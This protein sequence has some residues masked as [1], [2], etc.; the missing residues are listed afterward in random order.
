MV[1]LNLRLS[2]ILASAAQTWTKAFQAPFAW[3]VAKTATA[4]SEKSRKLFESDSVRNKSQRKVT[5]SQ[6]VE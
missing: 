4:A 2:E 1:K 6:A 3:L 5:Y